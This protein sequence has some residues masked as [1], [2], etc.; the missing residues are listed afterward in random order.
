MKI[1]RILFKVL[2]LAGDS[3]IT[4]LLVMMHPISTWPPN[5][6]RPLGNLDEVAVNSIASLEQKQA[7]LVMS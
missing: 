5:G 4:S 3:T 6:Q 2:A 7:P 1:F